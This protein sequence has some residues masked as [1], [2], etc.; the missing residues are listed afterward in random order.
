MRIPFFSAPSKPEV[1]ANVDP[2][3]EAL[4]LGW[5]RDPDLVRNLLSDDA[6]FCFRS[7][8]N[9]LLLC[10]PQT[11]QCCMLMRA[12]ISGTANVCST[13]RRKGRGSTTISKVLPK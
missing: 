5:I 9:E 6:F 11:C 4:T 10:I 8:D 3:L 12:T 7:L 2:C 1:P 13:L